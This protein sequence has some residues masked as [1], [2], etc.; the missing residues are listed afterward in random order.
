M[1]ELKRDDQFITQNFDFEWW[2]DHSYGPQSGINHFEAAQCLTFASCDIYHPSQDELTGMEIAYGGDATRPL[3]H[4]P[5]LVMETQSQAFKQWTPY[6]GQLRLQAMAHLASGAMGIAYWNLFSLHNSAESYW[7]GV[8]S[9]DLE[10]GRIAREIGAIGADF[11]KLSPHLAGATKHSRVA[12]VIDNHSQSALRWFAIDP[13]CSYND[14]VMWAYS[15]LYELNVECDVVDVEALVPS[16]YDLIVTPGLYCASQQ[17]IDGLRAF[18]EKGGVLVSTLRSFVSDENVTIWRT[19]APHDL[20]YVFGML[21]QEIAKPGT[22]TVA[23]KPAQR[24]IELL[25]ADDAE[26]LERYEHRYWG[27]YAAL[28]ANSF[29]KGR[30]YYLAT[31]GTKD[32]LKSVLRRACADAGIGLAH[33]WP[34]VVR[35]LR[36]A[37]GSSIHFAMNFSAD[38]RG[39]ANPFGEVTD[40]LGGKAYEA[41]QTIDLHDW[42]V[43]VLKEA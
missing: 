40:L 43:V 30:A 38:V 33:E 24:M 23:G 34:L 16:D 8:L 14:L 35:S 11:A 15:C 17:V 32:L 26:V 27:E 41:G 29:G 37:D 21:Y 13:G 25:I 4:A 31:V 6:P 18:V 28:T 9:H 36:A 1:G 12:L 5:Y 42:D 39:F 20:T 19:R 10:E 3:L 7:K 2:P 22:T